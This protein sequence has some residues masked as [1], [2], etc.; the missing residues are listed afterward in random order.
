MKKRKACI[1]DIDMELPSVMSC[2][3]LCR[4]VDTICGVLY[5]S[6]L[7]IFGISVMHPISFIFH[8]YIYI[9]IYIWCL[10]DE[11]FDHHQ[12]LSGQEL[13]YRDN[14]SFYVSLP[15]AQSYEQY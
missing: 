8:I 12:T 15:P 3:V 13:I 7:S 9:Y 6:I 5:L 2:G 11:G 14:L 1:L 4:Y 10:S